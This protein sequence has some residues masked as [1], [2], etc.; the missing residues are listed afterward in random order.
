MALALPTASALAEV[1]PQSSRNDSDL[2]CRIVVSTEPLSLASHRDAF[3][4]TPKSSP[5]SPAESDDDMPMS[6]IT[7][8]RNDEYERSRLSYIAPTPR[9]STS[10]STPTS[11]QSLS[12]LSPV[13][14]TQFNLSTPSLVSRPPP[15]FPTAGTQSLAL[16]L[17][18]PLPPLP[19]VDTDDSTT[20][21]TVS[22][23]ELALRYGGMRPS[24]SSSDSRDSDSG[25]NFSPAGSAQSPATSPSNVSSTSLNTTASSDSARS[26][27]AV[28]AFPAETKP[29]ISPLT[30][31]PR[32]QSHPLLQS[33]MPP[34]G[35]PIISPYISV[36]PASPAPHQQFPLIA[37]PVRQKKRTAST[38]SIVPFDGAGR[39]H[40]QDL[41]LKPARTKDLPREPL[42]ASSPAPSLSPSVS[43]SQ[44]FAQSGKSTLKRIASK[45]RLFGRR[46]LSS[47]SEP[48]WSDGDEDET[49]VGH[50][51]VSMDDRMLRPGQRAGSP[52]TLG[53]HGS[54]G[55][56]KS[57]DDMSIRSMGSGSGTPEPRALRR[58]EIVEVTLTPEG[59]IWEPL[60]VHDVIPRLRELK[61]TKI[62][63]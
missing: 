35:Q 28:E 30:I 27:E 41:E 6:P 36:T 9:P 58:L 10:P 25:V 31:P 48:T 7:F 40:T 12:P 54:S 32:S 5:L 52:S 16:R 21:E 63:I 23:Q 44:S 57:I 60:E 15:V 51:S 1:M 62:K 3:V 8:G 29:R 2:D 59:E 37:A 46:T 49:V 11:P 22:R 18:R 4:Y 56:S 39:A 34:I 47:A 45:T 17:K 19:K 14:F 24:P 26:Y 43:S 50:A 42:R 55:H 13:I 38:T 53:S 33:K 61:S 20:T